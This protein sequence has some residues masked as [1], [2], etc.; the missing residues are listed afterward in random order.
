MSKYP[1]FSTYLLSLQ[2]SSPNSAEPKGFSKSSKWNLL[3][4][5]SQFLKIPPQ[6]PIWTS[7]SLSS[8][9]ICTRGTAAVAGSRAAAAAGRSSWQLLLQLLLPEFSPL[10]RDG[11]GPRDTV[12][13]DSA[14]FGAGMRWG[15]Y[16]LQQTWIKFQI[17]V[18]LQINPDLLRIIILGVWVNFLSLSIVLSFPSFH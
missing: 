5:H 18:H 4:I 6:T 9:L 1:H 14:D 2:P 3:K 11:V 17:L 13:R 15:S 16:P 7:T 10:E 8:P 12:E